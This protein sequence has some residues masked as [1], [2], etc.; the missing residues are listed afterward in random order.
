MLSKKNCRD[1]YMLCHGCGYGVKR[2]RMFLKSYK[3]TA[4]CLCPKCAK[5]LT[6]EINDKY[7][8]SSNEITEGEG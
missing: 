7:T 4:I 3:H 2:N 5:E 8:E 1:T 6:E